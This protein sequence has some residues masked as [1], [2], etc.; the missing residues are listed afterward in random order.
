ML[1]YKF[2]PWTRANA[3]QDEENNKS[4]R[5]LLSLTAEMPKKLKVK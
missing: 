1:A 2:L 4:I 3:C 5:M